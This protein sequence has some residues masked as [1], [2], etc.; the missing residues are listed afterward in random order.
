MKNFFMTAGLSILSMSSALGEGATK[1]QNQK[2]VK[3]SMENDNPFLNLIPDLFYVDDDHGYTHGLGIEVELIPENGKFAPGERW[4]VNLN[5][6]LYTKDITPEG[7]DLFP[8]SPQLF[9]EIT[10]LDV[11]WDNVLESQDKGTVYY[12]IGGGIGRINDSDESGWAGA[13]QQRRWH[14]YKH[15]EL[16]PESTDLYSNQLGDSNKTFVTAKAGIGKVVRLSGLTNGCQCEINR[17]RVEAGTELM[18]VKKG[19]KAYL[20]VGV[21]KSIIQYGNHSFGAEFNNTAN[22]HASGDKEVKTYGG[23][24]YRSKSF[25]VK[26]GFTKQTGSQNVDFYKY[27]DDDNIWSLEIRKE[28][29]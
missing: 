12:L 2:S 5:T 20:F 16:T 4:K 24:Y 18:S 8:K 13:G 21:D 19:S 28:F 15:H 14:D 17:V 29:R 23:L 10:K 25:S 11:N 9:N 3:I 6:S 27:T 26:T 22:L 7:Q 1:Y